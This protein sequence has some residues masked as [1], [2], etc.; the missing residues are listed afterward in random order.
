MS[1]GG[2]RVDQLRWHS[3][4]GRLLSGQSELDLLDGDFHLESYWTPQADGMHIRQSGS[5]ETGSP[6]TFPYDETLF[7]EDRTLLIIPDYTWPWQLGGIQLEAGEMGEVIRFNPFTWRDA[8]QDSGPVWE[9]RLVTVDGLEEV[10]TPAGN[11]SAWKVQ[12]PL[13]LVNSSLANCAANAMA[14]S[15]WCWVI[16]TYFIMALRM[17]RG[18]GMCTLTAS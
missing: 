6:V 13:V 2:S 7:V 12:F 11:Y 8:T 9:S 17:K 15:Y 5:L 3:S 18:I 1:V 16:N 14:L 4:D 10:V